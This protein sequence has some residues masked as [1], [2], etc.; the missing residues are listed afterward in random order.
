MIGFRAFSVIVAI[1][2]RTGFHFVPHQDSSIVFKNPTYNVNNK[3]KKRKHLFC[4]ATMPNIFTF[5]CF[6]LCV[7]DLSGCFVCFY[8]VILFFFFHS[9]LILFIPPPFLPSSSVKQCWG[10]GRE[11]RDRERG[12][13]VRGYYTMAQL[14]V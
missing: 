7:E 8:F 9:I 4:P 6:F 11:G 5:V 2:T 1:V 3:K 14:N 13:G 12:A 10:C